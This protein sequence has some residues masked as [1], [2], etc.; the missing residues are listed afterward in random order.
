MEKATLK[1]RGMSCASCANTI[2]RVIGRV[3]GVE[4]CSVNFGMEQATVR[5]NPQQTDVQ[6][7]QNAVEKV[8]YGVSVVEEGILTSD[9]PEKI[10]RETENRELRRKVIV[11]GIISSFLVMGSLPAMTGLNLPWIPMWLHNFWVQFVLATPIQFWCGGQ[12]YTNAWKAFKRH[13]ATMD[14]LIALGTSVAYLYSS[15]VLIF[16]GFLT[17]QG[18]EPQVYYEAAVVIITLVLLGRLLESRAKRQTSEA[19]RK[20]MGLQAKT[21]RIIRDDQEVDIPIEA[22]EIGDMVLVRPG[23][24]IPI[25]GEVVEGRST[26]DESMVTGESIPVQK[27]AGDE[28]IGATIN[29][30]GRFKFRTTRIGKDTVLAQI[31]QLVQDAQGSKAPIQRLTDQVTGA[32]VPAVIA[33]AL[34]TFMVW[35]NL[36][37]NLTLALITTV[38]VLIIACPC[39]LGLATPTSVMVGTGKGAEHGVLIKGADSLELAH[40]IQTIVLDKTGTLTQGKPTVTDFVTVRG[41]ANDN[42]LKLIRFAASVERNSEHPLAEAVVQYAKSQQVE[43]T[44][45]EDFEAIVGSGVQGTVS[46]LQVQ[47]GTARWLKDLGIATEVLQSQ[48]QQLES[49]SKTVIWMAV[50]GE[51]EAIMGITDA[52]KPSSKEVVSRLQRMGL[53]VVMLT[54]DNCST[55]ESIAQEVGIQR[56]LAEVR[57]D[58]KAQT[59]RQLQSEGKRVAM[60]GDGINDAPA[61]AQADLGIAIGTGTDVAIA[62]SDITLIS[63]DLQGIITAIQLSHATI[64]NIKQNLFFAFI[65]NVAGIPIAAGVL[66]PI[67]GWLLNPII[68]GAA[69]AFSSVSV[70]TNALRLRNFKPKSI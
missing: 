29:K 22:V 65:Y 23:E 27:Q 50:N 42:E 9:D 19:I 20:L 3:S 55:A 30:T 18:L 12:F 2:E 15:I 52:L 17:Q 21:A 54:G 62:A 57:P 49:R 5:Y 44:D 25:D 11:G 67:F 48:A 33:I 39:A 38:G 53:E 43:I 70:V 36:M 7:I 34:L 63:G 31:V 24:K 8:G 69:M 41:T 51:V 47:I 64:A 61:L 59:I 32:F 10:A 56:I 35:F 16:P 14:T 66:F 6:T 58:Q 46:D 40:K 28:V 13:T 68:A 37:G 60:V 45:A 26:V 4:E 1:L